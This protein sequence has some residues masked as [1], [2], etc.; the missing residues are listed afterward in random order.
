MKTELKNSLEKQRKIEQAKITQFSALVHDIK[1]PLTVVKGN[2]EM[3]DDLKLTDEQREFTRYI[4]KNACQIEQYVKMLIDTIKAENVTTRTFLDDLYYQINALVSAKQLRVE[5]IEKDLP[6][7]INIDFLFLQRAIMS[8]VS[9]ATDYSP[10]NRTVSFSV[11]GENGK[12]LFT[13][14]DSGKGFSP[15]DMEKATMQFYQSD[16]SRSSDSHYG[17]GLYIADSI[18]K[19]HGELLLIDNSPV[20]GGGMVTIAI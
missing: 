20:T 12:I 2:A 11:S 14:T 8:I 9:N 6:N 5:F 17:M 19:Q 7:F 10:M 15:E 3:L 1:T 16:K 13:V 18:V 4:I